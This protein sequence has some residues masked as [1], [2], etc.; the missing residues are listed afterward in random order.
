MPLTLTMTEGVLP[1]G[2]SLRSRSPIVKHKPVT[3]PRRP[4]LFI[5]RRK[6]AT[7]SRTSGATCCTRWTAA[8][9]LQ[10]KRSATQS[11]APPWPEALEASFEATATHAF[12]ARPELSG[13][14]LTAWASS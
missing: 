9:A 3:S 14:R 5:K 11:L 12:R 8:G 4:R 7:R 6:V 2:S 1:N 13:K 10:G